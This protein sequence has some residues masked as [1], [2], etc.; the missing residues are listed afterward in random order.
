MEIGL[1][2][3]GKNILKCFTI[4]GHFS[5]L[6]HVTSINEFSFP[7]TLKLTCIQNFVENGPVVSEK[8]KF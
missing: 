7:C 3:P 2:V 4:C 1:L 5:H 6:S 8:S